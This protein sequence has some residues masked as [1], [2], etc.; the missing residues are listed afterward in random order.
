MESLAGL[1]AGIGFGFNNLLGTIFEHCDEALARLDAPDGGR[2]RAS[3]LEVRRAASRGAEMVAHLRDYAALEPDGG[4]VDLSRF[5]LEAS[6]F[7]DVALPRGV[8]VS[9]DISGGPL[10][11]EIGKLELHRVLMS[12]VINAAEAIGGGPGSIAISTG[13]L[14][15]DEALLVETHGWWDP[16]PGM[17]AFLRVADSGR[18]VDAAHKDRIF[19]PFYTTRFA[20]R[21]LGLA[22]VVGILQRH[23]AVVRVDARKPSGSEFSILF[24]QP[25][26]PP[27][28]KR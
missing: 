24:P 15:A 19:D 26:P 23:R 6:T 12:L 4:D 1:S 20:G 18:G 10:V 17:H 14:E 25:A 27:P 21:G 13:T 9:Y 5:V 11:V 8:D 16:Q 2:L 22:G 3:L 7:L 28:A